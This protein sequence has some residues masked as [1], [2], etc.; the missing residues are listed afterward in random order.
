MTLSN[1]FNGIFKD[2]TVLV[3]GH[4]GF[5][6]SWLTEWLCE[7]QANVIGYSLEP[8]TSPSLFSALNLEK[9]ISHNIGDINDSKKLQYTIEK[10]SP[11]IIFHLAAQ[12]LVKTSYSIPKDTFHT[13]VMGTVNLLESIR[14]VSSVKIC[15]VITSDKCYENRELSYAYK[16][17]DPM[18][19]YD[20]YSASKGATELVISSYRNS[21][22]NPENYN[23]HGVSLS[24]SRTGNVIGGGDW[25]EN[26]IVPDCVKA[27]SKNENIEIR[28]P[29][30]VRPWQYVLEPIS[31]LFCLTENMY[32]D[33]QKY[34]QAWN[35]GPL[36]KNPP[37]KVNELS[38]KII[39][40]WGN[41]NL[42]DLSENNESHEAHLLM[43]DSSKAIKNLDW[44]P[45]YSITESVNETVAW[46]KEFYECN[47]KMDEFSKNQILNYS[48][49][50]KQMNITWACSK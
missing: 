23:N 25:A 43:L 38:L 4:T 37:V 8:P 41:G 14:N 13:N 27:L 48:R 2:K 33:P 39:D 17:T 1:A 49:K 12:P 35:F 36:T 30:S 9:K 11:E 16:E 18:G 6:G 3:T 5:I 24:S 32:N 7:L 19:G 15:T 42:I 34:A 31:G 45:V 29:D 28:N 44:H 47:D 40:E 21:F 50:A 10:H 46:Y 20:P 22:F 26:R